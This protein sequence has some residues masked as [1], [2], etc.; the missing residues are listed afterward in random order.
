MKILVSDPLVDRGIELLKSIPDATVVVKTGLSKEALMSEIAD[1][2]ALLIRSGTQVDADVI[3]AARHL[4]IIGRAGVG[5]DNVDLEAATE[6]GVIVMNTPGGNTV[7]TAEHAFCLIMGL[8]RSLPQAHAS[9]KEGKWDRKRFKGIELYGKT[10]GI[11]GMGRVGT[12]VARRAIAFGMRVICHDPYVPMSKAR[13]MEVE[14]VELDELFAR[15]DFITCHAPLTDDTRGLIRRETIARMKKGV[16]IVNCA[17][18]GIVVEEDLAEAIRQ[19]Q[20]A[21]AALD[22]YQ[23][24][25]PGSEWPLRALEPVVLT[26]HLGA[27]TNE[28]QENVG[29]E[30]AENVKEALRGGAIRNAVNMPSLDAKTLEALGPFMRFG[31][32][33]GVF[34]AA[35]A[36]A[37]VERFEITYAGRLAELE[38]GPVTRSIL[39]GFLRKAL[40]PELNLVNALAKAAQHGIEV[41]ENRSREAAV[42]AELIEI[43]V[44]A[45]GEE[46]SVSGTM[47]GSNTMP[48]IVRVNGLPV[49]AEP[50]GSLLIVFND[51][52]P[53]AIGHVGKVLGDQG[54]NIAGMTCGRTKAAGMAITLVNIDTM[55]DEATMKKLASFP[56]I[57][58]V[59]AVTF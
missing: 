15:A 3:R 35:Y 39:A 56:L 44:R 34:L 33:L 52:R 28:A 55:P 40:G 30:I 6:R 12:E 9:V 38:T 27:S 13:G 23:E 31:E 25:P 42:F 19:G 46:A 50:E 41:A 8:A 26:P 57:R 14:V 43:R 49:E 48:R 29:I 37:R 20:V 36:P 53:G 22:V 24:E 5:V 21:G 51:D 45:D 54:V 10:L 4:R 16:R 18:G 58:R 7:S 47:Y 17:R 2:E 32:R 59:A 1:C 11:I